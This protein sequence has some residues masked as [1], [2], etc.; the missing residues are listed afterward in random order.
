MLVLDGVTPGITAGRVSIALAGRTG[1]ASNVCWSVRSGASFD[2][3]VVRQAL[4]ANPQAPS[5]IVTEI[6]RVD[7]LEELPGER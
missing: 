2:S 3:S 1:N 5:P 7:R 4:K 6:T